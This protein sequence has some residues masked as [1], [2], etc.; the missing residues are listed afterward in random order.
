MPRF[1]RTEHGV[2]DALPPGG[3]AGSKIAVVFAQRAGESVGDGVV[4]GINCQLV[5]EA[6]GKTFH[7]AAPFVRIAARL[8]DARG[9]GF[10]K[11]GVG[12]D[13]AL[14]IKMEP[15]FCSER[16]VLIFGPE[17]IQQLPEEGIRFFRRGRGGRGAVG[18][19]FLA[20]RDIF[21]AERHRTTGH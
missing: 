2:Q 12:A 14:E 4:D 5:A 6:P 19:I 7:A 16:L 8:L 15:Q 21:L 3:F 1:Q 11:D 18:K 10:P 9:G 17:R 20:G 13:G